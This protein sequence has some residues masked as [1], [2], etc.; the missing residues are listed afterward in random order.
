MGTSSYHWQA[1]DED[2][3]S[4]EW[5]AYDTYQASDP[6]HEVSCYWINN[7][8]LKNYYSFSQYHNRCGCNN[9]VR[10]FCTKI[11]VFVFLSTSLICHFLF[12]RSREN[13]L[14]FLS[15][16]PSFPFILFPVFLNRTTPFI[17]CSIFLSVLSVFYFPIIFR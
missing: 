5:Q 7:F 16:F 4:S 2:Q 13:T 14:W 11:F 12:Y 10:F 1:S 15:P 8:P 3:A 17:S 6:H 9:P